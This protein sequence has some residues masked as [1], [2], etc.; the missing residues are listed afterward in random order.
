M[1]ALLFSVVI[2]SYNYASVLPRAIHSVLAQL[3]NDCELIVVDDGS[4]DETEAVVTKL[5]S[6]S[7]CAF[8]Y[9]QQENS[10]LAA[11]RN[12]GIDNTS[13]RY[14]IFLDADDELVDGSLDLLRDRLAEVGDVGMLAGGHISRE[15][16]GR[17]KIHLMGALPVSPS[18]R[19]QAYLLDKTLAFSNG[20]VAINRTVFI[21]CR[22]PEQ[23][24]SSEDIPIFT[25]ILANESVA[26]IAD[27][28]AIIHKHDDSLRHNVKYACLVGMTLVDEVFSPARIDN[29][30]QRLRSKFSVQRAL[31]L[32]RTLY[33]SGDMQQARGFYYL[34][35]SNNP[36]IIFNVAYLRKF[37]MSWVK[38]QKPM[39]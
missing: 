24:R 38:R 25:T 27:P 35:V 7:Q 34:A 14:L 1:T 39:L 10:G 26:V 17:E 33:L 6:V 18:E 4:T 37:L 23:F 3:S 16:N 32:F 12:H 28:V 8:R 15:D 2:P 29:S 22:Y 13:G 31:S 30:L 5:L 9:Y 21:R 20:A 36:W 19:L 11:T